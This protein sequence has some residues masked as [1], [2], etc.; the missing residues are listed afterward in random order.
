MLMALVTLAL[1]AAD[2]PKADLGKIQGAWMVVSGESDGKKE[3]DRLS[4]ASQ[5]VFDDDQLSIKI[6]GAS[7]AKATLT[8]DSKKKPRELNAK[9]TEGPTKGVTLKGIY[10]LDGDDLKICWGI[11]GGPRPTAFSTSAGSGRRLF[12]LKREKSKK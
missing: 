10:E 6:L 8:L 4:A 2:E 12:V 5:F 3:P 11:K 9:N 1:I 7:F